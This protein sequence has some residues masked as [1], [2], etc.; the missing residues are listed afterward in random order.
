MIGLYILLAI[1][2]LVLFLLFVGIKIRISYGPDFSVY[3][4]VLGIRFPLYPKKRQKIRL[5]AF[6]HKAHQKRL[7]RDAKKAEKKR[8]KQL[9][10]VKQ[11]E[12]KKAAKKQKKRLPDYKDSV[13]DEK[14][15]LSTLLSLSVGILDKFF[16]TLRIDIVHLHIA[17]GGADASQTAITYGLVSQGVAYLLEILTQKTKLH[18][19]RRESIHVTADFLS[20]STTASV[21][22]VFTFR[23]LYFLNIT[24]T[25]LIRFFKQK[26]RAE[27]RKYEVTK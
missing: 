27:A 20:S 8:Q 3:L 14:E 10:K 11:K 23:L 22:L 12:A 1:L 16:G 17:V 15:F 13:A 26:F 7:E 6:S 24:F 9:Q 5:S 18:C 21:S 4:S 25:L 2:V 19:K